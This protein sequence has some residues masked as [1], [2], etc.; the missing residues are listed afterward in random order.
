MSLT[1][2]SVTHLPF[3][4]QN[5]QSLHAGMSYGTCTISDPMPPFASSSEISFS[6]V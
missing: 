4:L 6:A 3:F 5:L 2:S 1:R